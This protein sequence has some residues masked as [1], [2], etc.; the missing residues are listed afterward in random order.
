M[1]AADFPDFF[2]ALWGFDPF[3][4]QTMLAERAVAGRWPRVLS[5]PT[6]AGK[7]ACLDIAVFALALEADTPLVERR[8]PRRVWFAVDRRI[9]VDE[10][11]IRAEKVA[12]ALFKPADYLRERE[13]ALEAS[14]R[15]SPGDFQSA[16]RLLGE[17]ADQLKRI[18]GLD[19]PD[20]PPLATARLRGG[21]LR[22]DG[23]ARLPSQPAIIT[24]TV[25]QLGSRL[26]FRAY[27]PGDSVAPIHAAL[28][29]NDSLILLDEAHCAVPFG[30]T[31]SAI[32]RFRGPLWCEEYLPLPFSFSILSATPP[33]GFEDDVFPAAEESAAALHHAILQRRMTVGK[34]AQ[35]REAKPPKGTK[36]APPHIGTARHDDPLVLAAAEQACAFAFSTNGPRVGIMVNRVA[37]AEAI[38]NVLRAAVGVDDHKRA[39]VVLLTGRMRPLDRDALVEEWSKFLRATTPEIPLRPIIVVTTQCLEVGADFSFDALVT[40]CASLDALRQ[41]FGRLNR[42]GVHDSAPAVILARTEDVKQNA[43]DP[44]YGAA[45]AQTWGWLRTTEPT[46]ENQE[47]VVDFGNAAL[48]R[49]L[50]E[51]PSVGLMAP[52]AHAPVLLPAH[53]DMLCQ[54][55]PRPDPEPEIGLFLHGKNPSQP[56]ASVVWRADLPEENR[57]VWKDIVGLLP[58]SSG[59]MLQAPLF[60]IR[61]WLAKQVPARTEADGDVESVASA[62]DDGDPA[63]SSSNPFLI[64]RGR[65]KAPIL[66]TDPATIRPGDTVI[67]PTNF[68]PAGLG[69]HVPANGVGTDAADLAERA[70]YSRRGQAVLRVTPAVLG[71]WRAWEPIAN[72]LAIAQDPAA[73]RSDIHEALHEL[74][75]PKKGGE[76]QL[77]D[78]LTEIIAD[79]GKTPRSER[80]PADGLILFG[81]KPRANSELVAFDGE[82]ELSDTKDSRT[83]ADHTADALFYG[84]RFASRCLPSA[85]HPA[86]LD[87]LRLHDIGKLDTRFQLMLHGG[88]EI[89]RDATPIE[90]SLAKSAKDSTKLSREECGLP[91]EFAHEMLSLQIAEHRGWL[92]TDERSAAL[93]AHLITSHHGSAR[94]WA[95]IAR[96]LQPHAI[97]LLD[98]S[99]ISETERL[100]W[101]PS[102]HLASGIGDRFW[103]LT[104]RFG[105]WGLPML[106]AVVRL[107]DWHASGRP[108]QAVDAHAQANPRSSSGPRAS[109]QVE[110]VLT[111]LDPSNPLGWLATLGMFRV[112]TQAWPERK[113]RLRWTQAGGGWRPVLIAHCATSQEE[114]VPQLIGVLQMRTLN[115]KAMFSARL[116]RARN[117]ASPIGKKGERK[118][119]DTLKYPLS[120]YLHFCRM[121]VN[122][123]YIRALRTTKR[124]MFY[125]CEFAASW[126][127]EMNAKQVEEPHLLMV[128]STFFDFTSGQQAFVGKLRN[129]RANLT[130]ENLNSTL[131]G[132]WNYQRGGESMRWDPIDEK[133]QYALQ[134]IDPSPGKDAFSVIAANAL[135]VEALPLFPTIPCAAGRQVGVP[136]ER[137]S[138]SWCLWENGI[139]LDSLR[140]LLGTPLTTIPAD[141]R[142][143]MGVTQVFQAA[144]AFSGKDY[145]CFTRSKVV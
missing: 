19:H 136:S 120:D 80:H 131:M 23:W 145:R 3:P 140:S 60:R 98:G 13:D 111:G 87:A 36:A 142:R 68:P 42:L 7:T 6:A 88:D 61:R 29:A 134:A 49:L 117:V 54:T 108:R 28:A 38:A 119:E 25:D 46:I 92:S 35:L 126:A 70:W 57:N 9:V 74:E 144:I 18:S 37:T 22:D 59:E 58:P 89:A 48:D 30:Q 11:F 69:Q 96:D 114:F 21:V 66:S 129:L 81:P 79:L 124:R 102:H 43:V 5:L 31:L 47:A 138:Y 55:S 52:T 51:R 4:W 71:P 83:L 44:I 40:E 84:E 77:A 101:V 122:P 34:L 27:G 67:V 50:V 10:A 85:Y 63:P 76:G 93:T 14:E 137:N 56:Q 65:K 115:L 105:W 100:T 116:D 41:R 97:T 139:G 123:R 125:R 26:L 121:A 33:A 113:L 17:V 99:T 106:E 75:E 12:K 135:A 94:P 16:A 130:D 118:W 53:L 128:R 143:A 110:V 127:A 95:P 132:P 91:G 24:S 107:T 1:T 39:D 141:E 72:L 20:A 109:E 8:A 32:E 62:G 86:V 45:L 2:K 78:W 82:D 15:M 64:W 73:T 103:H 133:R 112:A 104:R 90:E